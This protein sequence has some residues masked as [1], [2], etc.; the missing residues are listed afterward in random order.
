VVE[1]TDQGNAGVI[2]EKLPAIER[3][4]SDL[5]ERDLTLNEMMYQAGDEEL[6]AEAI[7]GTGREGPREYFDPITENPMVGDTEIWRVVNLTPDS[8]PIHLHLVMFQ[9]LD[10]IPFDEEAYKE[11][12]KK[13]LDGGAVGDPPDPLQFATG[14]PEPRHSWETGWKDTVIAA[15]GH[16]TRI[17]ANFDLGGLYVWHCHI[18]EHEDN[19]MMRPFFVGPMP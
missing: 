9:V 12:Q 8:H 1:G 7:M 13:Y 3:L 6:P 10:R 4:A 19:E 17:I 11:A 18:L 5:P 2:P 14:D 16:V 15:P